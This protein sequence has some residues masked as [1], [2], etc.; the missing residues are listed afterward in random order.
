MNYKLFLINIFLIGFGKSTFAQSE[1]KWSLR[2]MNYVNFSSSLP[3][4]ANQSRIYFQGMNT[5]SVSNSSG[6]S[7]ICTVKDKL[8]LGIG[9]NFAIVGD[10]SLLYPADPM[11]GFLYPRKYQTRVYNLE[12]PI[13]MEYLFGENFFGHLGF[14][15]YYGLERN[16]KIIIEEDGI[17]QSVELP[18]EPKTFG[19]NFDFSINL[20]FGYLKNINKNSL[21]F[22][23]YAQFYLRKI[24]EI[25]ATLANNLPLRNFYSIGL[26]LSYNFG[27]KN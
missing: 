22:M 25:T 15:N 3:E 6:I 8:K 14:S 16:L 12:N 24:D 2:L 20:G 23:P 4:A 5:Y 18:I 9:L 26:Q 17:L 1:N 10:R 7:A 21:I 19:D 13:F 11:R 27:R